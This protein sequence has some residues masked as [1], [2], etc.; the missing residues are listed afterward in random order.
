MQQQYKDSVTGMDE[1]AKQQ[2]LQSRI[3]PKTSRSKAPGSENGTSEC[4]SCKNSNQVQ[5]CKGKDCLSVNTILDEDSL[6]TMYK[7]EQYREITSLIHEPKTPVIAQP[8]IVRVLY[9]GYADNDG[10][11]YFSYRWSY[12]VIQDHK[13]ILDPSA[14]I[15]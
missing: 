7:T 2:E 15:R 5:S 1:K 4:K 12:F 13:W 14:E 10:D 8:E 11:T 9:L 3:D 6:E